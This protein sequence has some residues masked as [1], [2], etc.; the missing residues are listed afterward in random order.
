MEN[1]E[2]EDNDLVQ[3]REGDE[4]SHGHSSHAQ[5]SHERTKSPEKK[6]DNILKHGEERPHEDNLIKINKSD[7]WKYA[8]YILIIVIIIGGYFVVKDKFGD[9]T[10]K[11]VNINTQPPTQQP[12]EIAR[13][14]VSTDDDA[15]KGEEDAQVTIIEFSDYECPF[16]QRFYSQT[17]TQ[18]QSQ[19]IDTGKA[20]L[21][22]RDFPLSNIH[23][24]AQKAAEAAECAGEQG[25]YYEMHDKLFENGVEGGI[26]GFKQYAQE[27]G[28]NTNEFNSCLDSGKMAD[29]ISKDF[30]DGQ[31]VGVQ[32]TPAFFVNGKLISGAQ[33][34]SVFQEAIEAEL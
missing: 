14:Q 19:Y 28:L 18:I 27:I 12:G 15:V 32:G 8:V 26:A 24:Q 17:L 5:H 9:I 7:F 23:P 21:V 30:K 11:A 3:I 6:P 34:F 33:P 1:S 25:K 29:E 16:C 2:N 31:Q 22:Y 4:H 13:L 10:G 20:K